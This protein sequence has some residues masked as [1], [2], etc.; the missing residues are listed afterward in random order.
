MY[1]DFKFSSEGQVYTGIRVFRNVFL[2][3]FIAGIALDRIE[4][5]FLPLGMVANEQK[6]FEFFAQAAAQ[7]AVPLFQRHYE[8]ERPQWERLWN[9]IE[10]ILQPNAENHFFGA[11]VYHRTEVGTGFSKL[12]LIDGQQRL[13]TISVFLCLLRNLAFQRH[14]CDI[15]EKINYRYLAN[16]DENGDRFLRLLLPVNSGYQRHYRRMIEQ[17]GHYPVP[18][19]GNL[20]HYAY[21]FFEKKMI[22]LSIDVEQV[23]DRLASKFVIAGIILDPK[24]NPY[25]ILERLD[26][27]GK[28]P[29][30]ADL[31]RNVIFMQLS[32]DPAGQERVYKTY[33]QPMEHRLGGQRLMDFMRHFLSM[34]RESLVREGDVCDRMC[35]FMEKF[36]PHVHDL[37]ATLHFF[38]RLYAK[39]IYVEEE[40]H[41]GIRCRLARLNR[42]NYTSAHPFLLQLYGHYESGC[43]SDDH[44]I[45]SLSALENFLIRRI[46]CGVPTNKLHKIFPRLFRE[47]LCRQSENSMCDFPYAVQSTLRQKEYP[48]DAAFTAAFVQYRFYKTS[49]SNE[50][51]RFVLDMLEN[52]LSGKVAAAVTRSHISIEHIMPQTLSEIWKTELGENWEAVHSKYLHTIGNL[53]LTGC[54]AELSNTPYAEKRSAFQASNIRLNRYFTN[55][56]RWSGTAILDRADMLAKIAAEV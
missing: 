33:W 44:M 15:A 43:I 16:P 7:F 40:L 24:D 10:K 54:N 12:I 25:R 35:G 32:E 37:L 38:A 45:H 50:Q 53:T 52:A 18:D 48:D 34:Q 49:G 8:W 41:D 51:C 30:S 1:D 56:D 23:W 6:V 19:K 47:I 11:V 22:G 29:P 21:R 3:L 5:D 26:T 4:H 27:C 13:T 14:Q 36:G 31:I 2:S 42:L 46:V 9:N 17:V 28:S 39:I 20:L 55:A